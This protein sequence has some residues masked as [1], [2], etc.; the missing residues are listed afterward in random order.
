MVEVTYHC[1]YCGAVTGLERDGYLADKCVTEEPLDGWEYTPTT[2]AFEDAD[3]VELVCL[4]RTEESEEPTRDDAG[5]E[6]PDPDRSGCGRTYY[7]SF[8]RHE[9]GEEVD[10]AVPPENYPDA[11]SFEFLR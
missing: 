7:L 10:P 5:A 9:A 1:P 4:G 6:R 11:P 2:G 3:G 8:V